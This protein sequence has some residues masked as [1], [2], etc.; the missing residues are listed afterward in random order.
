VLNAI[1]VFNIRS[2]A[3]AEARLAA[4][5]HPVPEE[6]WRHLSPP[7]WEHVLL[8]GTDCFDEPH[9]RR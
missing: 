1:I 7:I 3:A 9:H 5:G 4:E 8:V 6:V 2:P